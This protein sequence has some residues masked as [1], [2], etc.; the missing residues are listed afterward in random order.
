MLE[1]QGRVRAATI[2]PGVVS[3]LLRDLARAPEEPAG[4]FPALLPGQ[5]VGRFELMRQIGRGG[6][7]VVFEARDLEL[8]RAV[9]FKAVRTGGESGP[10]EERL[11]SEAEAAARLSHPNIVTL[12]DAGRWQHGAY[13]VL[14]LLR[15]RTLAER[16][17][18]GPMSLRE[19][20][21]IGT[22]VV[23]GVAHAHAHG[24][25][26]RD[27]K[28]G[29]VF[30]CDDGQVKVLDLGMAHA[31]GRRKLEGGTPAYMA[32]EQR[33]GAPEDERTDVFALG[34]VFHEMLSCE[35]PFS[36][37]G[38]P[39]S[40]R[41]LAHE[42]EVPE[43]PALGELIGRMLEEDPVKRPR[44]AA[45][46]LTA[47]ASL[48]HPG[49][50]PAPREPSAPSP[51]LRRRT[52]P[53]L[54]VLVAALLA[55]AAVLLAE[56]ARAPRVVTAAAGRPVVAVADFVNQT[57]D[58]ELDGLSVMLITSLEQS[59]RLAV[60]TRSRMVDLARQMGRE[61]P[62]HIDEGLGRE[63]AARAGVKTLVLATLH[64][65]DD[66]YAVDLLVVDPT[67]SEYLFALN[68]KGRG[69][70]SVPA[71][72]DRLSEQARLR[73]QETPEEVAASRID[74]LQATTASFDAFQH[75]FRGQQ[76]ADDPAAAMKEFRKA[77]AID[78]EF[79]LAHCWIA[80]YGELVGLPQGER[81]AALK[82]ALRHA[83]KLPAKERRLVL[84][85]KAQLDGREDEARDLY[86]RAAEAYPEDKVVHFFAGDLLFHAGRSSE[87]APWFER[88]F[89]LDPAWPP[90]IAHLPIA[91]A[92]AGREGELLGRAQRWVSAAPS[93]AGYRLLGLALLAT[94]RWAEAAEAHAR[95]LERDGT[96]DSRTQ[97][98]ITL[99]LLDRYAEAEQVARQGPPGFALQNAL[100]YQ[101]RRRE[102]LDAIEAAGGAG[103]QAAAYH[104]WRLAHF[105][106]DG[107]AGAV[108]REAAA[109]RGA[110]LRA[111]RAAVLLALAGDLE[112]AAAQAKKLSPT[113]DLRAL[114][115]ALGARRRGERESALARLRLLSGSREAD[116]AAVALFTMGEMAVEDGRDA[117]AIEALESFR[118][119][120]AVFIA[121]DTS[122]SYRSWAYP[123]SLYLAAAAHHRLG[124]DA[125]ARGRL[126]RLFELWK[127]ADP[128]L[129]LLRDASLLSRQ[130]DPSGRAAAPRTARP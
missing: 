115:D 34:V 23:K 59:R 51:R 130:L 90:T 9:A 92:A 86:R 21:Q 94:A 96:Q 36:G 122:G 3:A 125:E 88:A 43:E 106:G 28:P 13:L 56:R 77:A 1:K 112:G 81:A 74:I 57:Q 128:G 98:A 45:E 30:L 26:H 70:A 82:A 89:E 102:A 7:G 14:E 114:V 8:G 32:P 20:L 87:S 50:T 37:D 4:R 47:L 118:T 127:Q 16:L 73:L 97:L 116:C 53:L 121:L 33:R 6:F 62:A 93:A 126:D 111:D 65:F 49:L 31:F 42:L 12:F 103:S 66:V 69:K 25:I 80:Y 54:V 64:R 27:L 38:E 123:R 5:I 29:N 120:S 68:E 105:L 63:I 91:F 67:R 15:G 78:P 76:L 40:E 18:Q 60:L 107:D 72:I 113:S 100:A 11:L 46:V 99:S 61:P 10:K 84:A 71:I 22:Q 119:A 129:P 39:P 101:G 83:D 2:A 117:D 104:A 41:R 124:H 58:Q 17:A 35:L 44:D 48:R 79:G 52:W 55:G 109:L 110:G 75:F 24:V 19:A 95:A 108:Q 85:W